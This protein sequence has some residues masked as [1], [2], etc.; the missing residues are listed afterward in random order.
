M[1]TESSAMR[2]SD[3]D[4]G[5]STPP[6]SP[7]KGSIARPKPKHT[8]PSDRLTSERQVEALKAYAS[9]AMVHEG[10]VTNKQAGD[11]INLSESTIVVTNAWFTDVGFLER[12]G[13]GVFRASD[14]LLKFGHAVEFG[15]PTAGHALKPLL[16]G[17]W[18]AKALLPY[19]S[20]RDVNRV[21]A[22]RIL[23]E[24]CGAS[25]QFEEQL[26]VLLDFMVYAGLVDEMGGNIRKA[27]TG[28]FP[29]GGNNSSG[30]VDLPPVDNSRASDL[31]IPADAPFM[32]LDRERKRKVTLVAPDSLSKAEVEKIKAWLELVLYVE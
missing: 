3:T 21:E 2:E 5:Q 22:V 23:A 8:L 29:A 9:Q 10:R 11:T 28:V 20:M 32:F 1:N 4:G 18:F 31:A 14:A 25:K 17:K 15:S 26:G 13:N 19:L 16:E 27:T 12:L 24:A 6:Q 7:P 30:A